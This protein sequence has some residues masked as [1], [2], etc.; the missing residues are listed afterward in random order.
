M[1][2]Y[3]YYRGSDW[4]GNLV[5]YPTARQ[6]ERGN[7]DGD[8]YEYEVYGRD[9]LGS[10]WN[11]LITKRADYCMTHLRDSWRVE[12][13]TYGGQVRYESS[14]QPSN[15]MID[16]ALVDVGLLEDESG[17]VASDGR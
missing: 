17:M 11:V 3:S 4:A 9:W 13:N 6:V 10:A 5:L 1:N 2:D 16:A 15:A 8:D 7:L 12:I 14:R